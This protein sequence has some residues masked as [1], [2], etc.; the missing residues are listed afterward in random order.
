[1]PGNEVGDKIHNF[2]S[3]ENLFQGQHLHPVGAN[4]DSDNSLWVNGQRQIGPLGSNAKP[5]VHEQPETS[6]PVPYGYKLMQTTAK[7]EFIKNQPHSQNQNMNVY[8]YGYQGLQTRPDETNYLG[9]HA[10][11]DHDNMNQGDYLVHESEEGGVS[12]QIFNCHRSSD[13]TA[14]SSSNPFGGQHQIS[15]HHSGL[16]QP[17]HHKQSGVS[18]V[19]TIQQQ[20]MLKKMQE[21]QRRKNMQ[22]VDT[23][24]NTLTN[25]ATAF[26]TEVSGG[27]S[28]GFRNGPPLFES[29]W[30]EQGQA[31]RSVGFIHQQADQSLYGVP[32]SNSEAVLNPYPYAAIDK[33]PA[34]QLATYG[35]QYAGIPEHVST[36][37]GTLVS[38]QGIPGDSLSEHMSGEDIN[39]WIN[40]E[41]IQQ[42]NS[43]HQTD[44][45]QEFQG[46]Q[47]FIGLSETTHDKLVTGA[48]TSHG[49]AS[50]DP[51]EE[52]IL[53]G[54]DEN[55]WDAFGSDI[56]M[57]GGASNLLDGNEFAS[58]LPSLQSGS[59]SALMQSAVAEASSSGAGLQEELTGVN[60]PNLNKQTPLA[61]VS[62][63][64]TSAMGFGVDGAEMKDKHQKYTGFLHDETGH[65]DGRRVSSLSTSLVDSGPISTSMGSPQINGE[66]VN[67]NSA[68]ATPNLSNMQGGT[69]LDQFQFSPNSHQLNQWKHVQSPVNSRGSGNSGRPQSHL[70]KG[71]QASES[72]FNSSDKEDI[73]MH[74][75]QS[76]SKRENS[77]D[78]YQ[79]T[80]SRQVATTRL[81]E[82]ASSDAGR[83]TLGQRKF[84]HH[85]MGNLNVDEMLYGK[86]QGNAAQSMSLQLL[87]GSRGQDKWNLGHTGTS[88]QALESSAEFGKWHVSDR[89]GI[90]K[91]SYDMR[92]NMVGG[93]VPNMFASS[94]RPVGLSASDK[95]FQH[96]SQ[97]MQEPLHKVDQSRNRGSELLNSSGHSLSSEMSERGYSDESLRAF[98]RS[99]S[100]DSQGFGLNPGLP[101]LHQLPLPD[102]A[103]NSLNQAHLLTNVRDKGQENPR[104]GFKNNTS[105]LQNYQMILARSQ[106]NSV[107]STKSFLPQNVW[108]AKV[109]QGQ[110]VDESLGTE[111]VIDVLPVNPISSQINIEA[112]SR[113][114]MNQMSAMKNLDNDLCTRAT[115]RLKSSDNLDVSTSSME[116]SPLRIQYNVPSN[117]MISVK[118]EQ[119]YITPQ[120]V[121]S[122]VDRYPAFNHSRSMPEKV[123]ALKSTDQA[124]SVERPS[125]GLGTHGQASSAYASQFDAIWNTPTPPS[126]AFEQSSLLPKNVGI[127][128]L[129]TSRLK[130]H[131][132]TSAGHHPWLVEVSGSFKNLQGICTGAVE[133]SRAAN[134]LMENV[135]DDGDVIEYKRPI[136]RP[137]R[138]LIFT[139]LLMQQLLRPPPSVSLK[140]SSNYESVLYNA[141][142]LALGDACNLLSSAQSNSSIYLS[143][144]NC[145][146]DK[147]EQPERIDDHRLSKAI[148]DFKGK[149]G[150][151]EDDFF[152]LD[153]KASILDLS[154]D[155]QDL[156][157][158]LVINHL[159]SFH[160]RGQAD[161]T[162]PAADASWPSP[163]RYVTAVPMSENLPDMVHCLSL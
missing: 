148:E 14:H 6:P 160:G 150:K 136:V 129:V 116:A 21:L 118:A 32:V 51:E 40:T 142:R 152:R 157:R 1:M 125:G 110:M 92:S 143:N 82:N 155:F 126:L 19:R 59:W 55:I 149:A 57:D 39:G 61:D 64:N 151:L 3:Q 113:S 91:G 112:F 145:L 81:R 42:L 70:N 140:A 138:R 53:F 11:S 159:A 77:N 130:K 163:K 97:D 9:L 146:S 98:Q 134:Q 35:N 33:V 120:M 67:V 71:S 10:E 73:K 68:V 86:L 96:S 139:T 18:D 4:W 79:S 162:Q 25:Q 100:S 101:S 137:K 78:S 115:K 75:I 66:R 106:S 34:Q 23:R 114:L 26:A 154:V 72:S 30:P 158:F 123:A 47:D 37:D 44:C 104:E 105:M 76:R 121:Q 135:D 17:L 93:L 141:A 161:G 13:F 20:L 22:Q 128:N 12:E 46:P 29:Y 48:D 95:A 102:N 156:E 56:N 103:S 41:Q 60:F 50:L 2:Y 88:G 80:S 131:R 45:E 16:Q 5:Y 133:W 109:D 124:F 147:K 28:H 117:S 63:T 107:E 87:Q 84:Q 74:E 111:P 15:G 24:Q 108:S 38:R 83:N 119:S 52:K 90:T 43:N 122:W 58:G 65:G 89:E 153:K 69:H 85:P 36:H 54:S 31:Q 127:H 99:Q 49:S 94:N 8:I 62:F 27:N 7:P 144:A 132:F